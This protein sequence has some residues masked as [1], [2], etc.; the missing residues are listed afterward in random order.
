MMRGWAWLA[1]LAGYWT[2]QAAPVPV[3]VAS[4]DMKVSLDPAKKTITGTAMLT[5][6]NQSPDFVPTLQFHLYL[7]AFKNEQTTFMR[8]LMDGGD[9]LPR[10]PK[11]Q[12]WGWIDVQ[13]LQVSGGE[14]L[15]G[16]MRFIQ[17][18]DRNRSDQTV[19]EVT[20]PAPVAPGQT[21]RVEMDFVSKLPKIIARTGYRGQFF[22]AGQWFPKLGVWETRGFRQR[23][24]AG[25]NCHQFHANS[26]FYANFGDYKVALTLPKEYM[27]GATGEQKGRREN[28]ETGMAEW[29][30]EQEMVTDF[31][32]TAQPDFVRL[33]RDFVPER[34][35]PHA[36]RI[37]AAQL[38]GVS[39]S[40]LALPRTKM[41]LLIQ[42]EHR[43]QAER[44]F[45]AL[46]AGLQW[47]GL[48]Y[49]PY[50]YR[51]ITLVDPP[52]G[53]ERAAGME[54]PT[55][56]T[57][58]TRWAEPD[59]YF[60]SDETVVHEFGHQYFKELVATN[61]FEESW[62]DEGFTH[63][64]TTKIMERV[65]G[66][67][68]LP[69]RVMGLNLSKWLRL[70]L[71]R[72]WSLNRVAYL[73][74][75][76]GDS[77]QRASWKYFDSASYERNSYSKAALTLRMLERILGEPVMAR[78]MRAYVARWRFGH[79][80][81]RDFQAVAEEVSGRELGWFFEQF[82]DGNRLLDYGVAGVETR[83]VE[84]GL[85]V[86]DGVAG[87]GRQTVTERKDD[88]KPAMY[89]SVVSIR[90]LGD[91]VAPVRV[92][93]RFDDGHIEEREWDGQYRWVRFTFLRPQKILQ[94]W[95]D[96]YQEHQ[97]DVNFANNT[98]Q[99]EPQ[100]KELTHWGG[101]LVFWLQNLFVWTGALL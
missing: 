86:F 97:L 92:T 98:W 36:E 47:F 99:H 28:A 42:P 88:G 63:Y 23:A 96:R 21:I 41:I 3:A 80:S 57:G 45:R 7:N 82:V 90:R 78:V 49:G 67:G 32:F 70:P 91:G 75:P 89:E 77:L 94:V 29:V 10:D 22:L 54:Y 101:T 68:R 51:T 25:W 38:L 52:A 6:V 26:E 18:D 46:K 31:A 1:V 16:R 73:Q 62:L 69:F 65:Y 27:V 64:A 83:K 95:V 2:L 17:P 5:W 14:D 8:G 24:E 43:N 56:I 93:I 11:R 55:F 100:T 79:P 85:G 35:I 84:P 39:E 9:G 61:E 71:L 60:F 30:F 37:E 33:E 4:Y 48:W 12:D 76:V 34:D 53:A 40:E 50:P 19:M 44:Q 20:L 81:T 87:Q 58:G 72:N 13:R 15:T 59:D 74:D 66:P